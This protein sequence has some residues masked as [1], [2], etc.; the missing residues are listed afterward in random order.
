VTDD[1]L[2]ETEYD[3]VGV[4]I[5][6]KV[7]EPMGFIEVFFDASGQMEYE[8]REFLDGTRWEKCYGQSNIVEYEYSNQG[9]KISMTEYDT[10]YVKQRF[11]SYDQETGD[12]QTEEKYEGGVIISHWSTDRYADWAILDTYQNGIRIKRD[13]L[14][15]AG[16]GIEW[17]T[18]SC[19][20]QGNLVGGKRMF[21]DGSYW[22]T[23]YGIDEWGEYVNYME[24]YNAQGVL[25]EKWY[26]DSRLN[27][28]GTWIRFD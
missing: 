16:L 6:E 18:V 28:E 11:C 1:I 25:T 24:C 27:S 15:H 5:K 7:Y 19:D 8:V 26:T 9:A 17:E 4:R 21:S 12:L 3:A 2:R 13:I 22:L 20:A 10:N 14:W 23:S